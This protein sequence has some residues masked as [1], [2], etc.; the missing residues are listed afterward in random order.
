MQIRFEKWVQKLL[1]VNGLRGLKPSW[2]DVG[3]DNIWR[4]GQD[5]LWVRVGQQDLCRRFRHFCQVG[6]EVRV[7]QLGLVFQLDLGC[8]LVQV[9]RVDR[10]GQLGLVVLWFQILHRDQ[11]LPLVQ[12]CLECLR[13]QHRQVVRLGLLL[14]VCHRFL[15]RREHLC[16]QVGQVVQLGRLDPWVLVGMYRMVLVGLPSTTLGLDQVDQVVP[17]CHQLQ[18]RRWIQLDRVVQVGLVGK[19]FDRSSG[20]DRNQFDGLYAAWPS[21]VPRRHRS[22]S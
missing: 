15:C 9:G 16:L 7:D 22:T 18:V 3:M 10:V 8:R 14:L 4:L 12:L 19:D 2:Y 17:S 13:V 11:V 6:L 20:N 5:C 21:F 1:I